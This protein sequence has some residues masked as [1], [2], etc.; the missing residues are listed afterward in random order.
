[1]NITELCASISRQ[2]EKLAALKPSQIKAVVV[3][4]L[5]IVANLE[6]L[7]RTKLLKKYV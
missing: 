1:M 4:T 7:E 6:N 5:N 2:D 3:G